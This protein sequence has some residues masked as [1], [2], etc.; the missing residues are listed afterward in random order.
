MRLRPAK[1]CGEDASGRSSTSK[2]CGAQIA[3]HKRMLQECSGEDAS[4]RSS[5]CD[6]QR[7]FFT[8]KRKLSEGREENCTARHSPEVD[9]DDIEIDMHRFINRQLC[10]WEGEDDSHVDLLKSVTSS[11]EG[12]GSN[13][14]KFVDWRKDGDGGEMDGLDLS[15]LR[16]S[17]AALAQDVPI[18]VA[19]E[20]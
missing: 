16:P 2:D 8:Q 17:Y 4:G 10:V 13:T 1:A 5:L 14:S 7:V 19:E 3:T 9:V 15:A 6:G 12:A 11:C 18:D 20:N